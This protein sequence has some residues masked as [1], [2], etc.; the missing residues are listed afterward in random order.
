M[1]TTES[2]YKSY[3]KDQYEEL[4][5]NFLI[6]NWSYS[7]LSSF[8]RNEKVFEMNYIYG[9]HSKNSST[10]VAGQ[11]YHSALH[12]YFSRKQLGET[13]D[14]V[15]LEQASFQSI[16]EVAA[17]MWKLQ[18]TTPTVEE[19]K[20]K[21]TTTV[22]ALL[23][24]FLSEIAV[25]EEEIGEILGAEI[26]CDE[27]LVINGVD[28]PLPCHARIDLVIKTKLGKIVIIDHKSKASYMDDAEVALS[29]GVQAITYVKCYEAKTGQTVDEVWFIENKYSQNKDKSPQLR[30]FK[31]LLDDDTRRLYEALLY[32]P[33]GKMIY[34]T[35]NPDYVY[36]INDSDNYVDRAELYEFWCR[37]MMAEVDDFNIDESKKPLVAKRL[38]KIR[39][40]S[41]AQISPQIIKKFKENAS[42]FIQYDLST[43]DMTQGEKIEHILRTFGIIAKVAHELKGYSCN[44]FLLEVSAGVKIS[45]IYSHRL[46]IA[47]ALDVETVRLSTDLIV[48]ENKSYLAVEVSKKR[49]TDLIFDWSALIENKI[50]LGKDNFQNTIVWD[51]DNHSTPHVLICGATGSG[52]SVQVKTI[53]EY[54]KQKVDK[55]VIFDPKFEFTNFHA[56]KV[57]VYNDIEDIETKMKSLVEEMNELVANNQKRRT[58]VIFDEF[59]DAVANSKSGKE[60]DQYEMVVVGNYKDGREKMQR[61]KT[62]ELKSLEENLRILL[63]K[64]RS[65]GFRIV[66]ATQ[67]ASVKVITGD[68]KVNFPVQICFRVPKETDSRVVLDEAGAEALAGMGDGLIKSPEYK[69]VVRYQA[70]YK[71]N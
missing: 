67:R 22:S 69:N 43:T 29:T 28:I 3:T 65:T 23:K 40:A 54:A 47:S 37:T 53:I 57:E 18:K 46:D 26:Y 63:Q 61:Q 32:E 16:D 52:K 44:T 64:G 27:F 19:C 39:D 14:L 58:L 60:L 35:S 34:A 50:P 71:P 51:L 41:M 49:E 33:L 45:S 5:S 36:L 42:K 10:T 15:A 70:Y 1:N 31:V 48:Y 2:I 13:L 8:S 30:N 6:S 24:N 4:F 25:Y 59:A 66:G 7:K 17:N 38:K 68:A 55:I 20:I 12:F 56:P 21:A 62:G 9:L 11:S